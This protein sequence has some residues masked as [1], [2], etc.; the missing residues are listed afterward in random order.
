M[1]ALTRFPPP[2]QTADYEYDVL[3]GYQPASSESQ[4]TEAELQLTCGWHGTCYEPPDTTL[5]PAIDISAPTDDPVYA[6]FRAVTADSGHSAKVS[7]V[8]TDALYRA[9]RE[10]KVDIRE[11]ET[12]LGQIRY[13]HVIGKGIVSGSV[14]VD[15]PSSDGEIT[16]DKV[17]E[18][19]R[20]SN[21][22]TPARA[23]VIAAIEAQYPAG[24]S[25][26]RIRDEEPY[27]N[28]VHIPFDDLEDGQRLWVVNKKTIANPE[29]H[30]QILYANS[31]GIDCPT[32]GAHVHHWG[33]VTLPP[34]WRNVDYCV[35]AGFV[36]DEGVE[37]QKCEFRWKNPTDRGFP[38][39]YI[40][41]S[42]P[43]CSNTW[44]FKIQS[45][46][47]A[48]AP[49]HVVA[50]S[51]QQILTA[52]TSDGGSVACTVGAAPINCRGPIAAGSSVTITATPDEGQ[53]FS[54]W[55]GAGTSTEAEPN[56]RTVTMD[57]DK[58]LTAVFE[59]RHTLDITIEPAETAGTVV[60]DPEP[61]DGTYA[62]DTEVTLTADASDV[63]GVFFAWEFSSW[64]GAGTDSGVTRSVT[65]D[66]DKSVVAVFRAVCTSA[67][68]LCFYADPVT[69]PAQQNEQFSTTLPKA[70]SN[71]GSAITYTLEGTL[72]DGVLFDPKMRVLSGT[73]TETG[74]FTLTLTASVST[75]GA[76]GAAG[77]RAPGDS[78]A[79][80]TLSVTVEVETDTTPVFADDSKSYSFTEG[81][82]GS[83]TLPEATGG[84]GTL[85]YAL[86][87]MPAHGLD[88]EP[89]TRVLSGTP[90]S[91]AAGSYTLTAT[92]EDDDSDTMEISVTVSAV[93]PPT[94]QCT[95]TGVSNDETLGTVSGSDTVDCGQPVPLTAT[96]IGDNVFTGWSGGGCSGTATSCTVTT[97]AATPSVTV[98][99]SFA[100]PT[101]TPTPQCT[102]VVE[103]S[104]SG[105]AA[106]LGG[107]G[108]YPCSGTP[109]PVSQ[110]PDACFTFN[111]WT[112]ATSGT[113]RTA[114]AN[115]TKKRYTLTVTGTPSAGGTVSGGGTYDCGEQATASAVANTGYYVSG[116]IDEVPLLM[117]RDRTFSFTFGANP[118]SLTVSASPSEA[119]TVSGG[120]IYYHGD[121]P[122]VSQTPNACWTFTG[123]TGD[124]TSAM[125]SN[126]SVTANYTAT[127]YA[128]L[129]VTGTPSA[130]GT[131]SGG[132]TVNCGD[133]PP[134]VTA[135]AN[136]CYEFSHWT[137]DTTSAMTSNRS[138]TANFEK[139]QYTL[140]VTGT[141]SAGGTVSGGGTYD[142]G[143]Q[144]TASAVANTGYYVSGG[145]DEVTLL[146]DRDRTVSFYFGANP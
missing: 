55:T 47:D 39:G 116:G 49:S 15:F 12:L 23:E 122:S 100:P 19:A 31:D 126:R 24:L 38:T 139:P 146:M 117:D 62:H 18:V 90:T 77:A 127:Q 133:P 123:W 54:G 8:T 51:N 85:S 83:K 136:Y 58:Q 63:G 21:N 134:S 108:S 71:S 99:G 145:I 50:C 46:T 67:V 86:S 11:G 27:P 34:V 41:G 119:G 96:V 138:V 36:P 32:G 64:S 16:L 143:E 33:N 28:R 104:P 124:T 37:G 3:P 56:V 121:T 129:T 6:V 97:D 91:S 73:P 128:T 135:S 35:E 76:S 22:W 25:P 132:G 88:F 29:Y 93:T 109:P 82:Y 95:V 140:T 70:V 44:I 141:P 52:V 144:A 48:P 81:S 42:E 125:T 30:E 61:T 120:G 80:A 142:C 113:T 5:G 106:S 107:D 69:V 59:V 68:G 101:P 84:N 89:S 10:V 102:Q 17:A 20:P 13:V 7:L 115:Y 92:D 137:G 26:T 105:A 72:P 9:C 103:D 74:T 130:G 57:Q 112:Y 65:M 1:A 66:G 94:P 131:V 78:T 2:A 87:D 14:P 110:T 79:S 118:Y 114:T 111:G 40:S 98:T 75:S 53:A 4:F 43:L 45:S 60:A